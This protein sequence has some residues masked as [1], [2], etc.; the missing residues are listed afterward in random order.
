MMDGLL[1]YGLMDK[2]VPYF[3]GESFG[4]ADVAFMPETEALMKSKCEVSHVS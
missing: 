4:L 1:I 2:Q 3:T